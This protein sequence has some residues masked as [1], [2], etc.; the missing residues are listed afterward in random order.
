MGK[1]YECEPHHKRFRGWEIGKGAPH[2][3]LLGKS[4]LNCTEIPLPIY[5]GG[6]LGGKAC[7]IPIAGEDVGYRNSHSLLA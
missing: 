4:E 2:H 7:K 5:L 1:K 6:K 3:F